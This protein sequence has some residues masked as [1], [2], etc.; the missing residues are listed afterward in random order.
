MLDLFQAGGSKN[1]AFG[2]MVRDQCWF[3]GSGGACFLARHWQVR[4]QL[5]GRGWAQE[6]L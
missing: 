6:N 2:V 3:L 1:Y 5:Q 4:H